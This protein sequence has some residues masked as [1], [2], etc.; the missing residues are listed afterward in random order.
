MTVIDLT[1]LD[2]PDLVET[3]DFEDIYQEKL[4]H[5]MSIYEDWSAALESDPVVK[6]IELAAWHEVRFRARVNDAARA[7]MLAFA[8]GA[9]LENLAALL[10][11]RRAT[12]DPGDPD[13]Q[14]PM[15]TVL[16]GDDRLKLRTQMSIE[17]ATVAGPLDAYIALALNASADVLD[18]KLDQPDAGVVRLTILA[19][20][21][22]GVP[23][24]MLLDTVKAAVSGETVRP[25]ND[26]VEVTAAERID[27]VVDADVYVP[28]G[29]G[30]E[31]VFEARHEALDILISKN[32][33]LGIGISLSAL[34]GALNPVGSGVIDVD[35]REPAASI[36]CSRRQFA[37]CRAISL[38]KKVRGANA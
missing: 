36:V 29:P 33:K 37:N 11:V 19:A 31:A 32:R 21:G 4:A 12:I 30:G 1:A 6:L 23:G 26:T 14:P 24:P 13:A 34:Y 5:F 28:T 8:T 38:V 22:D 10:D 27:F 9:D 2:P 3:L 25:L 16:E 17:T 35:L 20:S 15:G 7:V 18:A